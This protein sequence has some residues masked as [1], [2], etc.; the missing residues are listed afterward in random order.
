MNTTAALATPSRSETGPR[1]KKNRG[2][3]PGLERNHR[4]SLGKAFMSDDLHI[5]GT[6][7]RGRQS[8]SFPDV[9]HPTHSALVRSLLS[10]RER[11]LERLESLETLAQDRSAA[12][13]A[14][15]T[16]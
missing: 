3:S 2:N 5:P 6:R 13:S 9:A 16:T 11:V 1:A 4:H 12:L 10:L 14:E 8:S 7:W 15:S